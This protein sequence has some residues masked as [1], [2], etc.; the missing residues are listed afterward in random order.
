MVAV[1]LLVGLFGLA[2]GSFLNVVAYRVPQD[3]SVITPP[4]ACPSCEQPIRPR[5]NIPVLGWVLLRGR[6]RDCDQAISIRYPIVE[7][8]TGVLF[9]LTVL[10]IGIR[11]DLP[12]HLWFVGL[13]IVLIVTDFD[14]H[15]IPNRILLPGTLVGVTL[16]VIG[17]A[18]EG[19]LL[20]VGVG[21][22]TG[23]ANFLLF[24]VI[25][26]AARGGF[27]MGD[28]KLAFILGAFTGYH[29]WS[30]AAV[31]TF[32]AFLLGGFVSIVLLVMRRRGRKDAIAFGPPMIVGAW[33][34][35]VWGRD[36]LDWYLG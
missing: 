13:T 31:G 5:D 12:A 25:A 15:R 1:A 30:F 16:L 27:G 34:A 19:R 26:L 32:L 2:I 36:I 22:L 7:A 29:A 11:W 8:V 6:C 33:L 4:S 10:V 21:L 24:L 35:I 18:L 9:A 17:G 3:L 28:V 20:D 23:A 14:H